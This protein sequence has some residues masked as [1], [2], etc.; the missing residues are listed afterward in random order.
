MYR[1]VIRPA[2][3]AYTRKRPRLVLYFD[4]IPTMNSLSFAVDEELDGTKDKLFKKN[5]KKVVLAIGV[6]RLGPYLSN[7][8]CGIEGLL[9]LRKLKVYKA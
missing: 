4:D 2:F 9:S 1:V 3:D 7:T 5:C 8:V 6:P